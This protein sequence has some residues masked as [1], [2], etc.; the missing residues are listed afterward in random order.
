MTALFF[1]P[2]YPS[3]SGISLFLSASLQ[4]DSHSDVNL[5][6]GEQ[7]RPVFFFV[8]LP[9]FTKEETIGQA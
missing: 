1:P 7:A 5:L 4:K 3:L 2:S 6:I 8:L 9:T